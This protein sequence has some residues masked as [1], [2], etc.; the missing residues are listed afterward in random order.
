M[1]QRIL[2]SGTGERSFAFS[3]TDEA[4]TLLLSQGTDSQYGARHLKRAIERLLVQPLSNLIASQQIR[5]GDWLQVD[6]APGGL[7]LRFQRE[8]ENLPLASLAQA[9]HDGISN[10]SQI[11]KMAAAAARGQMQRFSSR[12]V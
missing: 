7:G 3:L 8:E 5:G 2:H 6:V 1:Q 10:W 12:R 4:K 9:V 11:P